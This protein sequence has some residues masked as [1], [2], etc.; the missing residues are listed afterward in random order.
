MFLNWFI[1]TVFVF[2]V[3]YLL[4][5]MLYT[6]SLLKKEKKNNKIIQT[7]LEDAEIMIRKYQIQLQRSLGDIDLLNNELNKVK[8]DI[9]ALRIRN[10]QYRV[11]NEKLNRKINELEGKIEALL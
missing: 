9:K 4:I 10:S 11:E 2:A 7:T 6:Q 1:L 5:M 8:N 3:I